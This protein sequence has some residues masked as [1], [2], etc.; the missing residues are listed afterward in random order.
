MVNLTIDNKK[1]SSLKMMAKGLYD[2]LKRKTG[3]FK[4]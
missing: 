3:E 1:L 4:A 2:G